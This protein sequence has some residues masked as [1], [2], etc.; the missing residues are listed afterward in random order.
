MRQT[1]IVYYYVCLANARDIFHKQ[2]TGNKK[3]LTVV[4]R[5]LIANDTTR[6]VDII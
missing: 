1:I 5:R 6:C 2:F 3:N 4:T